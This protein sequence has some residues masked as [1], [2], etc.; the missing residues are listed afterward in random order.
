[1]GDIDFTLLGILLFVSSTVPMVTRRLNQPYSVGLVAAGIVLALLPFGLEMPLTSELVFSVFLP[2]LEAAAVAVVLSF[3]GRAAAVYPIA[4]LFRGR[5]LAVPAAYQH[6]LWRGGLRGASLSS[7]RSLCPPP[8]RSAARSSRSHS[9]W[10][11][12]H[13]L[14][15]VD[16]GAADAAHGPGQAGASCRQPRRGGDPSGLIG[17]GLRAA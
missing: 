9:P 12:F 10:W 16:D 15:G 13:L 3:V 1:M 11:L 17:L 8:F 6:L 7:W 4:A 14:A 5:K 2:V